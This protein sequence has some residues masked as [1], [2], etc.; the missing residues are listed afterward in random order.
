VIGGAQPGPLGE[1]LPAAMRG[2]G[3]DDCMLA[4]FG[5]LGPRPAASG[6]QAFAFVYGRR[7]E[8][9][10]PAPISSSIAQVR[11]WRKRSITSPTVVLGNADKERY[12]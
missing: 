5:L 9:A 11:H 1:Y 7:H 8:H 6:N 2:G 3:S 10:R 12:Q 4:R